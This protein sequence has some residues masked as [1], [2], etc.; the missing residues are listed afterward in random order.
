NLL[1]QLT[2]PTQVEESAYIASQQRDC[3]SEWI[4]QY[5][6]PERDKIRDQVLD[7]LRVR[8]RKSRPENACWVFVSM[9]YRRDDIMSALKRIANHYP[10][11]TGDVALY[12]LASLGPESAEQKWILGSLHD[13]MQ[14]RWS[15]RLASAIARIADP[16]SV[17]PI[18][19][20]WLDPTA[21]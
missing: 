16:S 9:G 11:K 18:W 20:Y 7:K 1:P 8:L 13:R 3:L 15:D 6:S 21:G 5:P 19:K 4:Y 14:K 10:G 17:D 2:D 12:V